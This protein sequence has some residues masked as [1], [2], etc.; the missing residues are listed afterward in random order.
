MRR[1]YSGFGKFVRYDLDENAH[2][3]IQDS[4][5]QVDFVLSEKSNFV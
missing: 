4:R 1:L 2:G 5:R 3:R